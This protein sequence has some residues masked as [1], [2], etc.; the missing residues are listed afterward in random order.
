M[1]HYILCQQGSPSELIFYEREENTGPKLSDYSKCMVPDNINEFL[2]K[3]LGSWGVV[4]KVRNL[5]MVGKT[6]VHFDSVEGLGDFVELEVNIVL[7]I[8]FVLE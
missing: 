3:A 7:Y 8:I 5:M 1:Y 2:T 6:R 4:K